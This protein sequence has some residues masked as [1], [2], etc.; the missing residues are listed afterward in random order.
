MNGNGGRGYN[1]VQGYDCAGFVQRPESTSSSLPSCPQAQDSP[2]LVTVAAGSAA[3]PTL[4]KLAA[5]RA[6]QPAA[7]ELVGGGAAGAGAAAAGNGSGGGGDGDSGGGG[8]EAEVPQLPVEIP[9]GR[10]F[11]FHS[12]FACPVSRAR[13]I[14]ARIVLPP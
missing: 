11:V 3:L 10:E 2:L 4:L 14:S 6:V 13:I 8:A 7:G 9:L 12:I 1:H 5:V